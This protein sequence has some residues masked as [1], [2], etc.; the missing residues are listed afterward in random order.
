[1]DYG[2]TLIPVTMLFLNHSGS[3]TIRFTL[4]DNRGAVAIPIPIMA[5]ANAHASADGTNSNSNIVRQS[6]RRNG[7][8]GSNHQN[9]LH[10]NFLHCEPLVLMKPVVESSRTSA[11]CCWNFF[12]S[13]FFCVG[14]DSWR[15]KSRDDDQTTRARTVSA[16][17]ASS[18]GA[19]ARPNSSFKGV[20]FGCR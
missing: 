2:F 3:V 15:F 8:Y 13:G 6:W 16:T 11:N 7:S 4:L 12:A 19:S 14:N 17:P 1:M 20:P 5:F 10:S 18:D 9:V